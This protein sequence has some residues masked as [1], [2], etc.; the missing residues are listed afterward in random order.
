MD[1]VDGIG[2]NNNIALCQSSASSREAIVLVVGRMLTHAKS[3][4]RG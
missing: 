4:M 3:G 2:E 1:K